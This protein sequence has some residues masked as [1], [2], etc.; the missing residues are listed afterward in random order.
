MMANSMELPSTATTA[1]RT[2][3][4]LISPLPDIPNHLSDGSKSP[5][6]SPSK[7]AVGLPMF[8][9]AVATT[10]CNSSIPTTAIT[11]TVAPTPTP[12]ANPLPPY[13]SDSL[14]ECIEK[15]KQVC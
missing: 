5:V 10:S 7:Q 2:L 6:K 14:K 8:A 9:A 3:P 12:A 13:L 15:L 4:H 11:T 1:H